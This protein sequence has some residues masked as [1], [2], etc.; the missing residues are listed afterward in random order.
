MGSHN[1]VSIAEAGRSSG[2]ARVVFMFPKY[3]T[4]CYHRPMQHRHLNHTRLTLAAIDDIIARGQWR[5][6]VALRRAALDDPEVLPRIERICRART[7]RPGAQR[8]HFWQ[9]YAASPRQA[10]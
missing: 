6:W 9:N 1:G 7:R 5:H 2:S 8:F 4:P 3:G 10:A